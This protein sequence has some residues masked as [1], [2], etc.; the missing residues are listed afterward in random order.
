MHEHVFVIEEELRQN[1]PEA[2]DEE[3]IVADAVDRL[4]ELADRGVNTIVDPTVIGLGR[5]IRLVAR[6]NAQV[7]INIIA[8]TGLYTLNEVPMALYYHR[9]GTLLGGAA[10]RTRR[11][12]SRRR[13]CA[14]RA[15]IWARWSSATA[16]T[17]LTSIIC[18]A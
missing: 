5:D 4:R 16:A 11:A 17:P 13:S 12:W 9:P 14:A 6:V 2:W 7:D 1:Y 18:I 3:R 10:P 8:A 15:S